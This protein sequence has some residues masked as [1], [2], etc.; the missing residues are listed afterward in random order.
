ML[1]YPAP[2]SIFKGNHH[3]ILTVDSGLQPNTVN[4]P[5]CNYKRGK[6]TENLTSCYF[7]YACF[8]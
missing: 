4:D 7:F 5:D 6:Q 1:I 8:P 3:K 2:Y